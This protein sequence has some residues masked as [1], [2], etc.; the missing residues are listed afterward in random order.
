MSIAKA[1]A[2]PS[3]RSGRVEPDHLARSGVRVDFDFQDGAQLLVVAE[4]DLTSSHGS[5]PSA[6]RRS[7]DVTP[8]S[9][10]LNAA[11]HDRVTVQ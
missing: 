11:D 2:S 3:I 4:I 6:L 1:S 10:S 9:R 7:E 8:A 5:R